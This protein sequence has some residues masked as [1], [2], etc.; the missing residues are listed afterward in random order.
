MVN[1]R[2]KFNSQNIKGEYI[3]TNMELSEAVANVS[4]PMNLVSLSLQNN[5]NVNTSF[6]IPD[7]LTDEN[8][9]LTELAIG[10][11]M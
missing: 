3:E 5:I 2:T 10:E 4:V 7:N 8:G 11:K 6:Y 9:K 1:A